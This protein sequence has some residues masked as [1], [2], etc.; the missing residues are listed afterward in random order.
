VLVRSITMFAPAQ[1]TRS[2]APSEHDAAHLGVLEADALDRVGE[3]DRRRR[4]RSC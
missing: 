3:L 4:G 1:K 2:S